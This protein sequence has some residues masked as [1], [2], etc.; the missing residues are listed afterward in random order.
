MAMSVF[1]V[2]MFWLLKGATS[3]NLRCILLF[4]ALALCFGRLVLARPSTFES[5]LFLI[6]LAAANEDDFPWWGHTI[7]GLVM[8]GFYYLFWIY[9]IPLAA[10]RRSYVIP[11]VIGLAGWFAYGGVEYVQVLHSILTIKSHRGVEI[12]EGAPIF[13]AFL[14]VSFLLVPVTLYWRENPKRLLAACF[15]FLS[16][17]ARYLEVIIPSFLSF[18]KHWPVRIPQTTVFLIVLTLC[19]YRTNTSTGNSY[20]VLKD[21]VPAGSNVLVLEQPAMF[22]AVFA[23]EKVRISPSMEVGWDSVDVVSAIKQ[24][25]LH[26]KFDHNVLKANLYDYIIEQNLRE[27]PSGLELIKVAGPYRVWKVIKTPRQ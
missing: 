4:A 27:I 20:K 18:M 23:I 7:I 26:G 24:A 2:G 17:Q 3:T 15:F 6:A 19:F 5:G 9:L 1:A 16:N 10:L 12:V 11:L 25:S 13:Y 21:A 8:A 22:K 14:A